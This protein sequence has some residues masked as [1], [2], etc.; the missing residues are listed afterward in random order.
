MTFTKKWL[1][2]HKLTPAEAAEVLDMSR[3]SIEKF[4]AG[5]QPLRRVVKYA[6]LYLSAQWKGK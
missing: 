2:K 1:G 4:A 6:M 3:S 5:A